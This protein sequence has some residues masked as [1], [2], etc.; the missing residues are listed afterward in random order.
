MQARAS[1]ILQHNLIKFRHPGLQA[2][3]AKTGAAKFSSSEQASSSKVII[4]RY[5]DAVTEFKLNAPKALNSVDTEMCNLMI[6]ELKQWDRTPE[7]TPRVLLMSGVGGKAFCA[8]GDI[9]S[10]YKA[11]KSE[12]AD[13]SILATF[14]AREYLLD[15]SLSNMQKTT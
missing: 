9:V 10:L 1:A 11:H 14:F 6:E 15:Y 3:S 13:K 5:S 2:F 12:T 4:E 8:G 7:K